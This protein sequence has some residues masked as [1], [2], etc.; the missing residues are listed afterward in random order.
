MSIVQQNR[1]K[2]A[3]W[4]N[5][6]LQKFRN[7]MLYWLAFIWKRQ[8]GDFSEFRCQ[9]ED[10]FIL[11]KT[12]CTVHIGGI[13][14]VTRDGSVRPSFIFQHDPRLN[15]GTY[16]NFLEEVVLS[17]IERVAAGRPY[18]WQQESAP[19]HT[20]WRSQCWRWKNF[21]DHIIPNILIIICGAQLSEKRTKLS[22]TLKM[23]WR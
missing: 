14:V 12:K 22:A 18:I 3:P 6:L 15:T 13:G 4:C 8:Y 11:M 19:Y 7:C 20:S 2:T 23:N 17:W 9:F 16:I 10:R 21:C 1:E 5:S